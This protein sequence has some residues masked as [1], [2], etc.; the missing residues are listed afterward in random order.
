MDNHIWWQFL[1]QLAFLVLTDWVRVLVGPG[2]WMQ[3]FRR[4]WRSWLR[5]FKRLFV[6]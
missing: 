1:I 4:I 6:S 3:R 2:L 5:R